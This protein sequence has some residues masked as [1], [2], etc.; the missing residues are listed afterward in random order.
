MNNGKIKSTLLNALEDAGR[1]LETSLA[2]K[3]VIEKKSELSL[4][5]ETDKQAEEIVISHIKGSFHDHAILTEESPPAGGS[6]YRWIIDPLDGT[7]NFVHGY[8]VACVSIAFEDHGELVLGGIFDP[9][10]NELFIGEKDR[11]A[12]LNGNS[13][14][15]SE[16]TSLEDALVA[17]GFPYDRRER[18]DSY[19]SIVKA[20]M[21]KIQGLRRTG[22]AALDL[23]YIACGRF[24]GFWEFQLQ[25]WDK[26][27]GLVI[28]KEAG[29]KAT[30]YLGEPLT[31]E[32]TQNLVSNGLL[33]QEMLEVLEP[34]KDIKR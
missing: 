21:M 31:L 16:I 8:P 11:G 33:H 23:A 2:K 7:T 19:L 29:A 14:A 4:V 30:N 6:P 1:L 13:I 28:L 3:K 18:P 5:T 12:T 34:F 9:F 25:P 10:R 27:A 20:F 26:A 24:D 22:S 15:V 17:T 32:D